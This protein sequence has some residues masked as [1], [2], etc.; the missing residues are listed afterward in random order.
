MKE[1]QQTPSTPTNETM[2]EW[3][4]ADYN[5]TR[6]VIT[7]CISMCSVSFSLPVKLFTLPVPNFD[8]HLWNAGWRWER[9]EG[10]HSSG[11]GKVTRTC[12]VTQRTRIRNRYCDIFYLYIQIVMTVLYSWYHWSWQS[13]YNQEITQEREACLNWWE[14]FPSELKTI[15]KHHK[16]WKAKGT[17]E[18]TKW[19]SG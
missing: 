4:N 19:P 14:S 1:T 12:Q 2:L 16:T 10:V 13:A 11:A 3:V 17:Q 15:K 6:K 5:Q 18:E 9:R 7:K 8:S